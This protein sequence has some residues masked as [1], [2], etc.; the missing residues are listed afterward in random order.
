MQFSYFYIIENFQIE[1]MRRELKEVADYVAHTLENLYFLVNSTEGDISLEKELSLP[2]TIKDLIYV[3]EIVGDGDNASNITAYLKDRSF[4]RTSSW[5][6]P[7]LKIG[8]SDHVESDKNRIIAVCK[9]EGADI[10][11]SI[12]S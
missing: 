11:V 10:Y 1:M 8:T 2:S 12:S 5:L 4:I 7:G 9:R 6:I 3:V